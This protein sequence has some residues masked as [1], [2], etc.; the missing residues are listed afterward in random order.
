[1]DTPAS[2]KPFQR[3]VSGLLLALDG[4]LGITLS[5]WQI[6]VTE[7]RKGPTIAAQVHGVNRCTVWRIRKRVLIALQQAVYHDSLPCMSPV[8][9]VGSSDHGSHGK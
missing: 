2:P 1:M 8:R 4:S 7:M 6:F 3:H 9:K 5:D